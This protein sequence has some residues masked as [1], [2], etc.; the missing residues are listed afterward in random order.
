MQQSK[1]NSRPKCD[2]FEVFL[3]ALTV[4]ALCDVTATLALTHNTYTVQ[5][6]QTLPG[7]P[8]V[9]FKTTTSHNLQGIAFLR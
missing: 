7:T 4:V 8:E 2:E 3:T 1:S 5:C 6:Q 9:K